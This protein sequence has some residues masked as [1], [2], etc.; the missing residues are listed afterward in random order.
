[1]IIVFFT[2]CSLVLYSYALFPLILFIVSKVFRAP[3]Q[4]NGVRPSVS[5]IVSA[6]N[7]EDIIEDKIKNALNLDYPSQLIEIMISSDGSTDRTDEIVSTLAEERVKLRSFPGRFGKTACLNRVVPEARG[8]IVLFTDSNSMFPPDLLVKLVRNFADPLI[9]LVTGWTKYGV[10]TDGG[11]TVG[12]YSKMERWTKYRESMVASCVGADGA[13]FAVRK[14]LFHQLR[15][16]DINDFVIPLQV[17]KQGKRVILDPE[18]FCFEEPSRQ[19]RGEYHRQVRIS[20]RTL[21]AMHRNTEFLSPLKY[22]VFS[23]FLISHKWMRF[24]VPFFLL[25]MFATNLAVLKISY[26][27]VATLCGQILILVMGLLCVLNV[28]RAKLGEFIETFLITVSAQF[29]GW[30][31]MLCGSTDTVWTSRR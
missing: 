29:V 3:W 2:F 22:G 7:E 14:E 13:V 12:I 1:M 24:L 9:G 21:R 31:R 25:G 11:T 19:S 30:L 5:I 26:V 28:C 6:Y 15:E 4:T 18:V 10:P 17:I 16:D 23:F 8:D 20:T 27:F